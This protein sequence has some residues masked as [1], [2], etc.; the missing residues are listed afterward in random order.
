MKESIENKLAEGIKKIKQR[1]DEVAYKQN[2][3]LI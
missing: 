1:D 3:S 2:V